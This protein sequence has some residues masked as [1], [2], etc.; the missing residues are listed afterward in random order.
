MSTTHEERAVAGG[1]PTDLHAQRLLLLAG[2]GRLA[3]IVHVLVELDIAERIGDGSLTVDELAA[4]TGTHALSL[5]RILRVA[6]SVGIFKEGPEKV[7]S[8]TPLSDGLRPGHPGSVLPLVRYNTMDLTLRPFERILHSVRTGAPAFDEAFGQSFYAYLESHP[9][10]GEFFERFML[11]WSRRL[12]SE[13]LPKLGLERFRRIADLGGG[14]GGF[15]AEVL[16]RQPETTAVLMDLPRV[17]AS[18]TARLTDAGVA[19]RVTVV[20]GDFF[21]EQIPGDC[22]AYLLKGVLHNW[23]DDKVLELLHRL[24]TAIG[25]SQATLLV[26]DVVMSPDNRW[27]HGKFLDA[28]MLV[29][30]GGR[31][32]TLP[33]WHQ[34]F[35]ATGFELANQPEYRWSMLECRP[36]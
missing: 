32:R 2:A 23:S 13:E 36:I 4:K 31:E 25:N 8:A 28:D 12:I 30:F 27:D 16:R 29:L 6:A 34:L 1:L 10:A 21:R 24:R 19:D 22:D 15:L 7:F 17:A 3:R 35:A 26:F 11:H 18:A 20:P 14:D 5:Y 9:E 33:E